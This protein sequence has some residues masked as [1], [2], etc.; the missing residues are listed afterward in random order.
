MNAKTIGERLIELR[1]KRTQEEVAKA[2][3]VSISAIGMYERGERI[4][5]D[6]IK[7][8]IAKYYGTT[9]GDLFYC[10][11]ATQFVS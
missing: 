7:I 6:E 5:K 8:L 4:P 10:E 9:V 3:N 11:N 2:C 1:G